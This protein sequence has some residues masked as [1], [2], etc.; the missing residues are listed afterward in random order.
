MA[1]LHFVFLFVLF[2]ATLC[3]FLYVVKDQTSEILMHISSGAILL[4]LSSP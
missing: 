3:V 4:R 1:V 2:V